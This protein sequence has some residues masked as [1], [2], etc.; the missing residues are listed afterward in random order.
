MRCLTPLSETTPGDPAVR[1]LDSRLTL[2][3][4]PDPVPGEGQVLIR[5]TAS[6]VNRADVAQAR[7][8]YAPPA[9][10]PVSLGLECSGT[11]SAVGPGVTRW[12][13]GDAV[14]A[15]VSGGGCADLCLA[16]DVHVLPLPLTSLDPAA[17]PR[18][19]PGFSPLS[20]EEV[21]ETR[22]DRDT[23]PH[24]L[25]ATLVEAAA[26]SWLNLVEVGGLSRDPE[27]NAGRT[28]LVQGGTGSVGT[29]AIQIARSLGCRVLAT[30]G[31]P[32][33]A[34]ACVSL[35][36]DA[37]VDRHD[38]LAPFIATQTEGRGVDLVLDVS[39]AESLGPNLDA[40]GPGGTLLVI[41]LL[42]GS[43]GALDMGRLLRRNLTVRGTTLR[44]QSRARRGE[45]CDALET[46]VWPLVRR[47]LV[48]PVLA[49]VAPLEDAVRVH[50][51]MRTGGRIGARVLLP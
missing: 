15:L 46:W 48:R 45:V 29:I 6:G 51:S 2:L 8:R 34:V 12:Q 38:E 19:T 5:V 27:E 37:A 13:V 23:A 4:S 1:R 28:V 7:G 14:C 31:S 24:V 10:A 35:G 50:T 44:S 49:E 21:L 16:E 36:A 20:D 9:G 25:A 26:T 32:E 33:R 47:G 30:A 17:D 3:N 18:F 42:G 43:V 41:G 22:L 39:G 11:V 40:L